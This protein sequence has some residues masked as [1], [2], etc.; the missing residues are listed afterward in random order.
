[1]SLKS[2]INFKVVIKLQKTVFLVKN[3]RYN[4]MYKKKVI[5]IRDKY[6]QLIKW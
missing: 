4:W 5:N 1:M 2:L 6:M 3:L